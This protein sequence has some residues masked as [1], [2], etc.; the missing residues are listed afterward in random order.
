MHGAVVLP[1]S[2]QH[3]TNQSVVDDALLPTM[4]W[5]VQKE[6]FAHMDDSLVE[7]WKHPDPV[8]E[9]YLVKAAALEWDKRRD[10]LRSRQRYIV[11]DP[12]EAKLSAERLFG[13]NAVLK[14]ILNNL[15]LIHGTQLTYQ[16]IMQRMAIDSGTWLAQRV[17]TVQGSNGTVAAA[18]AAVAAAAVVTPRKAPVTSRGR[19]KGRGSRGE[20]G[21]G[22][23]HCMAHQFYSE[24]C[25]KAP[26]S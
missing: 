13:G 20:R 16:Q 2:N 21:R 10:D 7:Q 5:T 19:G 22:R 9:L 6:V 26:G 12:M 8:S 11:D 18:A 25:N 17:V 15:K 1:L 4:L 14:S 3:S 23:G 24:G